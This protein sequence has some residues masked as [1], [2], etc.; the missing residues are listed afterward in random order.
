VTAATA[1]L[2]TPLVLVAAVCGFSVWVLRDA[3]DHEKRGRPVSME[4]G[5]VS[6]DQPQQWA[7]LCLCL[8]VLGVPAYLTARR[9]AA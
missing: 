8:F 9:H 5:S 6:V 1:V 7:V 2:V 3:R 4:I